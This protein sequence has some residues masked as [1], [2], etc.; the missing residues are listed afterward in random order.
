MEDG[1]VLCDSVTT[2]IRTYGLE[3]HDSLQARG[4]EHED[5]WWKVANDPNKEHREL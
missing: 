4:E 1:M 5:R 3:N 2:V